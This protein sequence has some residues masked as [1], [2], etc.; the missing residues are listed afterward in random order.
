MTKKLCPPNLALDVIERAFADHRSEA[1]AQFHRHYG[2]TVRWA[3]GYWV[4]Q[5]RALRPYLDDIVQEVWLELW[6]YGQRKPLLGYDPSKGVPF[7]C[8][9]GLI[10]SKQGFKIGKKHL[11]HGTELLEEEPNDDDW[12]FTLTLLRED[13]LQKLGRAVRDELDE[14]SYVFFREHFIRGRR[15]KDVGSELGMSDANAFVFVGRLRRRIV[16]LMRRLLGPGYD[17][18]PGSSPP[19]AP[20]VVVVAFVAFVVA[21]TEDEPV[22]FDPTHCQGDEHE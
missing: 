15:I 5:W 16:Q 1:F 21:T 11:R 2:P 4:S 6:R 18:D 10:A 14:R 12:D 22:S 19:V 9:L 7:A 3:V 20:L 8:F 17:P 13:V